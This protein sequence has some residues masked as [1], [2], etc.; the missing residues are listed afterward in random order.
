ME[1][2]EEAHR[3]SPRV[4]PASHVWT[5]GGDLLV[6]CHDS[7]LLKINC[8]NWKA[9]MLYNPLYK[10]VLPAPS[11][12]HSTLEGK[13]TNR[14]TVEVSHV[15]ETVGTFSSDLRKTTIV[16]EDMNRQAKDQLRIPSGSLGEMVYTKNGVYAG[17]QVS[18]LQFYFLFILLGSI[19]RN[20]SSGSI[21]LVF[22]GRGFRGLLSWNFPFS[23]LEG[24]LKIL[25]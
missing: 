23:S 24:I 15:A 17:G 20:F 1:E 7:Q 25:P 8:T 21:V 13:P 19:S 2:F 10:E 11:R 5:E 4:T 16:E 3:E 12:P 22:A 6:G 9:R 14:I 18:F